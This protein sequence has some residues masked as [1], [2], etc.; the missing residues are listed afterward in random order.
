[1]TIHGIRDSEAEVKLL[2]ERA[3]QIYDS[4]NA[5]DPFLRQLLVSLI[6]RRK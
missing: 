3:I 2:S 5:G 6:D 1:M 4:L